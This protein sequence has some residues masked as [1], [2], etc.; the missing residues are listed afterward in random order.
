MLMLRSSVWGRRLQH[1]FDRLSHFAFLSNKACKARAKM[2]PRR[3]W[4][5]S[6]TRVSIL[7]RNALLACLPSFRLPGGV[8]SPVPIHQQRPGVHALRSPPRCDGIRGSIW[9]T[10]WTR[11]GRRMQVWRHSDLGAHCCGVHHTLQHVGSP[12]DNGTTFTVW[13]E[14]KYRASKVRRAAGAPAV[15]TAHLAGQDDTH[16]VTSTAQCSHAT[17]LEIAQL[18]ME[19]VANGTVGQAQLLRIGFHSV[20]WSEF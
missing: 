10:G 16:Q 19:L 15:G 8:R 9:W 18:I 17:Y 11:Q 13:K 5:L 2:R 3:R 20:G 4:R 14:P 1:G 7:W 6:Q 12:N